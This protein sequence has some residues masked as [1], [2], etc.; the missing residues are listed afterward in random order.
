MELLNITN[1]SDIKINTM[2]R[3]YIELLKSNHNLILSGAPGTGKTYMAKEIAKLMNGNSD[4]VQFHPSYD[5]TDFVEGLRPMENEDGQVGFQRKDGVFKSFCKKAI[6][7]REN[8]MSINFNDDPKIWKVSLERAYDNP[9]R[10]DCLKNGYIRIGWF[11]YGDVEDFREKTDFPEGGKAILRAFQSEMKVGDIV[12]SCYSS[13]E[14]DAI[15]IITGDYEYRENGG[16]YPRY[17]TVKWLLKDVKIKIS[18]LLGRRMT[19]STVYKLNISVSKILDLLKANGGLPEHQSENKPYI[20]IID[21]INRGELSK[22]FGELFY[23]IEPGYRGV[24][25][26]VKTQYQNLVDEND[27]FADGFYVPE[28]VY[29]LATM[30]D[31]DRSVESM[32]FAMRRRFIWKEVTPDDTK[33]M[34]DFLGE[35]LADYAK[36]T[37][38]CL[39]DVIS[40]TEGLGEAYQIGPAYFRKLKELNGDFDKLWKLNIQPLLKEYLR[41]FRDSSE[42]LERCKHAYFDG[43]DDSSNSDNDDVIDED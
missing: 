1:V 5:Y 11:G 21:E 14:T 38:K 33:Y 22:I 13:E 3:E 25:G 42:I 31:I 30:N 28:N 9:T 2:Y 41:G 43:D 34:L 15:G 10:T 17:R 26:K 27:V 23:S 4:F 40:K 6:I 32:D 39:N 36:Y 12:V 24:K 37:M 8:T 20:F 35:P 29:I 18:E 19:L 16:E 7:E